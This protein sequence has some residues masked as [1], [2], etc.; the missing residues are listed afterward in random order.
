MEERMTQSRLTRRLVLAGAAA[1]ALGST[2]GAQQAQTW[3]SR[4]I[5][6]I[7][8]WGAGGGTDATAAH[9]RL[10]AGKANRPAGPVV[11]RTGGSGA[12][13]HQAI[14]SADP[15]GYTIGIAT[16][17]IGTMHHRA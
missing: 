7:V 14:A 4:P 8:P 2:L 6:V 17:E 9:D 12:V 3:P 15:D 11:N 1:L 10:A 16:L 5:T 13:G